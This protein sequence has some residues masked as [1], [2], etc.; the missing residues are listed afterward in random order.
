M[1]ASTGK[2]KLGEG[3]EGRAE[4]K[5]VKPEDEARQS[6][7]EKKAEGA[8]AVMMVVEGVR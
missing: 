6:M 8:A 7:E 1:C 2:D 5:E 4:E 3:D